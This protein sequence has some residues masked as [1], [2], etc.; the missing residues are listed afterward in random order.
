ME[1]Y[2]IPLRSYNM[3]GIKNIRMMLKENYLET[4]EGKLK[5]QDIP[6]LKEL[7]DDL[8]IS[9]K[10]VIFTMGKGGVGKTSLAA[11]IA[12]GLSRKGVKVHLT[13]TDPAHH[14]KFV[15]F[16]VNEDLGITLS[17]INEISKGN[18]VVIPW[19]SE[20]IKGKELVN[21]IK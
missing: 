19:K 18:F 10:K 6:N 9:K 4:E 2:R 13:T 7:I 20:E 21:L 17:N 16:V 14:L 11:V 15:V 12:V 3:T 5:R 8:Y 1:T